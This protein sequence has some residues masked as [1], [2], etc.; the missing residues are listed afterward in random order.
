MKEFLIAAVAA[1]MSTATVTAQYED[2]Y[3]PDYPGGYDPNNP[4][5]YDP[6]DPNNPIDPNMPYMVRDMD[7]MR[8]LLTLDQENYNNIMWAYPNGARCDLSGCFYPLYFGTRYNGI[9]YAA[10]C[11]GNTNMVLIVEGTESV[12]SKDYLYTKFTNL[13]G[14]LDYN[15]GY[16]KII[17]PNLTSDGSINN[18]TGLYPWDRSLNEDVSYMQSNP[19]EYIKLTHVCVHGG[20]YNTDYVDGGTLFDFVS[21]DNIEYNDIL[22]IYLTMDSEK[23]ETA[24]FDIEGFTGY[25][26]GNVCFIPVS[27]KP[28][29]EKWEMP[30]TVSSQECHLEFNPDSMLDPSEAGYSFPSFF[31][32]DMA[33]YPGS[34]Y[35][36]PNSF[37][38]GYSS[39][40]PEVVDYDGHTWTVNGPGQCTIYAWCTGNKYYNDG[41][42]SVEMYV[43][44]ATPQYW[45]ESELGIHYGAEAIGT[46]VPGIKLVSNYPLTFRYSTNDPNIAEV[47]ETTGDLFIIS[48]GVAT[49]TGYS[50]EDEIFKG[51]ETIQY[52]VL[53][54]EPAEGISVFSFAQA[55][56]HGLNTSDYEGAYVKE[57]INHDSEP[58]TI[59]FSG[60][61]EG[62]CH[63]GTGSDCCLHVAPNTIMTFS[64]AERGITSIE[65]DGDVNHTLIEQPMRV[66]AGDYSAPEGQAP[67]TVSFLVNEPSTITRIS[68]Q[69]SEDQVTSISELSADTDEEAVY[70]NLQGVRVMN[71]TSGM[72]IRVSKGNATKVNIR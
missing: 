42:A 28:S 38:V 69:T 39:S 49:I 2:P 51:G 57:P 47:D 70:Y 41:N 19:G 66:S 44:K 30:L 71:P 48:G 21:G 8:F 56:S 52:C 5:G 6:Y 35:M 23:E 26:D 1:L 63:T 14:E 29:M 4:G 13:Y 12:T 25:Y 36:E 7:E 61:G 27:Y 50:V 40:N 15:D 31:T 9:N 65:F 67:G 17:N 32:P 64:H 59:T 55:F 18:P 11:D 3:N 22:N 62:Y 10:L 53:I 20:G 46:T 33:C 24:Y 16:L 34:V 37:N 58:L 45:L 54:D 43:D 72:Y 60:D 68:V